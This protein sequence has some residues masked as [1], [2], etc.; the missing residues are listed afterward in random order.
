MKALPGVDPQ[1][2]VLGSLS[3]VF[4]SLVFVICFKYLSLI[5]RADNR[6]EGGIFAL[7]ALGGHTTKGLGIG[8]KIIMI[9]AG[10]SLLFGESVITPAISVLSAAEGLEGL[11]PALESWVVPVAALVLLGLFLVQ[12]HGTAI[13]GG[14]FGPIMLVWFSVIGL[15]GLM[16]IFQQPSVLQAINPWMGIHLL[17]ENPMLSAALIGAVVL[18][19][20][21][22][23]ALY[24]DMGHF[25]RPAIAR[26]W[27]YIAFP[28]LLLNY[29]GQGAYFLSHPGSQ[30]HLF[31]ALAP[32]PFW[33]ACLVVLSFA[34]T[35]IASQ[36]LISGAYSLASQAMNLGYFPRLRVIHT[37]EDMHGQ[38]YVPGVNAALAVGS[39]ALVFSFG[40][41]EKL[42]AAYGLAVTGTMIVS[43]I[44]FSFVAR[45]NWKWNTTK[46][47]PLL[48]VLLPLD[49]I[50]LV[51]NFHK[52]AEGG[53][54]PLLMGAVLLAIM[55][56][57]KRGRLF[58]VKKLYENALEP[59]DVI[60]DLKRSNIFRSPGAA[61][62]MAGRAE[63]MPIVLIHHLKCNRCIHS[64]V[65]LLSFTTEQVPFV[66]SRK[67][68]GVIDLS[69]GFWRVIIPHGYMQTPDAQQ[70]MRWLRD[71]G[72]PV[73]DHAVTYFFN[74][75]V[76]IPSGKSGLWPWQKAL[77]SFLSRN[78][79]PAREFFR[80][81]SNQIVEMG[82][83]VQI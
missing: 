82:L 12:K 37:S 73:R 72:I 67:L 40:S 55:D 50:F 6:G 81:P 36:A 27:F 28:G 63:G 58:I 70:V 48:M 3:L 49:I 83:P 1:L 9:L 26:G 21:G 43:T 47:I 30:K 16:Q 62:F 24:A 29:F 25:G 35:V 11:N 61:V 65:I 4:W 17:M 77:Y 80:I 34:A 44:A 13:I 71:E 64:T 66:D 46:L 31:Y 5:M 2:A 79:L 8:F 23:E 78:A 33:E 76:V 60:Q 41:S 14:V 59:M 54:F 20:T 52:I 38:I 45:S 19:I 39:I 68:M 18:S 15:L 75:E 53:W 10:A 7:L 42:A 51:S 22:A 32:S 56:A 69:E 57:W 74:R